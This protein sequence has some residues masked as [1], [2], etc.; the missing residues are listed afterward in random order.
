[1]P[2]TNLTRAEAA[3]RAQLVSTK[4]YR[5]YLDLS[6]DSPETFKAVTEIDFDATPG[7]ATFLDL[8]AASVEK[9]TL[10]GVDLDPALY[11]DSRFPLENLAEHNT[12]RIESTQLYSR[13]GEGLHRYVDPADGEVYLYSQFEVAD[14]RRVY[15]N[16]EQ[17]DLKAR[18]E[19]TVDAPAAWRVLSNAK[20]P[21]AQPRADRPGIARWE[22]PATDP[23]STYLTALVAGPYEGVEGKPYVSSDGREIP[24]GVYARKS[25]APYLDAEEIF[26]ITKQGFEYFESNYGHPYPFTKYDQVFAPEYNAGAMENAGLVTIVETYVWRTKPTAAIVDRRAITILH[27]LAHMW[28][29]DLVTMKWWDDLWLNESFAE[30]MSHLAAAENTR[31]KDAWTTF[32]ASEKTW[33]IQQDQL[34]STHPIAANI[35]DIEDVLV[36]FDGITY[37]KGASV[38]KQLVN[39][40]G[41]EEFLAGVRAYIAKHKWG[42]ATLQDLLSELEVASGRDLSEWTKL[43]LQ[44]AGVNTLTADVTYE[45]SEVSSFAIVQS[46]DENSS[47]R[48]HRLTVTGYQL[49]DS[50]FKPIVSA[51]VDVEGE[52]TEVPEFVGTDPDFILLNDGDWT[53]A[54]LR[55]DERSFRMATENLDAFSTGLERALFVFSA[56]DMVRDGE[57]DVHTY[58]AIALQTLAD[59]SNGTVLRYVIS[60]LATAVNL[61]SDPATRTELRTEVAQGLLEAGLAVAAG[62]DEQKQI[63]D[64]FIP[65][66]QSAPQLDALEAWLGGTQVPAGYDVDQ[67]VRWQILAALAAVGRATRADLEAEFAGDQ[68]SYGQI[69]L[70]RAEGAL[71]DAAETARVWDEI[72]H[73]TSN[74]RQRN[75]ALGFS[76]TK[77]EL[78]VPYVEKYFAE[79]AR[80]WEANSVEIASNMLEYA[81]PLSLSGRTDLGVDLLAAGEEWLANTTAA[82]AAKRLVSEVVSQTQRAVRNQ[83]IDA[84]RHQG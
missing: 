25:L 67:A 64:S 44:E 51:E 52:R 47:L 7:A 80:M 54:K 4:T 38:L 28:F 40:V 71:A 57:L 72:L 43:W 22:F 18:F 58:S 19:F 26:T 63:L 82:P 84:A 12:V 23:I 16:F 41:L 69:G 46:N 9:A 83:Q 13:T 35:R 50:T 74:T 10:N 17:P 20:T 79:A 77:P 30:F 81:Y 65:L 55:F 62:S 49:D 31:W 75:L 53:Y 32:L 60:T 2:G 11:Q 27:E 78:L 3:Q 45:D 8:I 61:Y 5:I 21:V 34:P 33:A 70:A 48:P 73:P 6:G 39:Y 56:W 29:G 15:A 1:M 36:N 66:A 42:N 59:E 37:G 14:A 68:S 76:S 24:M